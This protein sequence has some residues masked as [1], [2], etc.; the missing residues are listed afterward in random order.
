MKSLIVP[1]LTGGTV[2]SIVNYFSKSDKPEIAANSHHIS[3]RIIGNV[4]YR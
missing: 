1:F 2:V 4:F 3:N